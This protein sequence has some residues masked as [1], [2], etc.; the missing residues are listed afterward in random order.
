MLVLKQI[1]RENWY[2]KTHLAC[3]FIMALGYAGVV[4]FGTSV[5]PYYV[6]LGVV[7]I[8][9]ASVVSLPFAIMSSKLTKQK[10]A[11]TWVF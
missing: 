2:G 7:G 5:I 8:G 3:I 9:W 1:C 4:L 6:M 11:Y 10:W